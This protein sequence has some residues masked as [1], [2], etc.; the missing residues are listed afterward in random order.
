[1][2][3]SNKDS[4]LALCYQ[5]ITALIILITFYFII[6]KLMNDKKITKISKNI[7]SEIEKIQ[8]GRIKSQFTG[9]SSKEDLPKI[10]IIYDHLIDNNL[11]N[12]E[13]TEKKDFRNVMT[14][15]TSDSIIYL[16]MDNQQLEIS[17]YS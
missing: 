9:I 17:S 3:N 1:M 4:V 16:T 8:K 15:T 2:A 11:I 10:D 12:F 6:Y 5:T 14:R 13:K 7:G